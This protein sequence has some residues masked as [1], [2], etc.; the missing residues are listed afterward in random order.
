MKYFTCPHCNKQL[1]NQNVWY[2]CEN[3]DEFWCDSC[4]KIYIIEEDEFYYEEEDC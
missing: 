1:I 2:S 4:R 3:E